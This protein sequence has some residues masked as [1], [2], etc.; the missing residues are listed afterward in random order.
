MYRNYTVCVH[1]HNL[2]PDANKFAPPRRQ[3]QICTRVQILKTP[4]T[5]PKIH[6]GANCAHER[7]TY[8]CILGTRHKKPI[9]W[10]R[11]NSQIG[12]R[13]RNYLSVQVKIIFLQLSKHRYIGLKGPLYNLLQRYDNHLIKTAL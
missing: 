3:E 10:Q 13:L 1:V 9:E 8:S 6:P 4:F 5:W 7:D 2:Y 11:L 12:V